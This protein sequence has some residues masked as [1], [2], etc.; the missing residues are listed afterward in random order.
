M[1]GET[2]DAPAFA[3][4]SACP[5]EKINVQLVRIPFDEKYFIAFTP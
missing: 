4:T 2:N 5:A 3:A 1:K